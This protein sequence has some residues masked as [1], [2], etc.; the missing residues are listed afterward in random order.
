MLSCAARNMLVLL[1]L[2]EQQR[3]DRGQ[4]CDV[5]KIYF[6]EQYKIYDAKSVRFK[7]SNGYCKSGLFQNDTNQDKIQ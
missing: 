7:L 6:Q 5:I 2:L 4:K 3:E 1:R